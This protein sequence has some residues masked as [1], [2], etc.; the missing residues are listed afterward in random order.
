MTAVTGAPARHAM[1]GDIN[2]IAKGLR[3]LADLIQ[4]GE[5]KVHAH[6]IEVLYNPGSPEE[7]RAEAGRLHADVK[8]RDTFCRAAVPLGPKVTYILCAPKGEQS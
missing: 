2:A 7:L 5:L 6:G 1:S 8:D 4:W 3:E